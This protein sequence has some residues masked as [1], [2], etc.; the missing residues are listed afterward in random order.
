MPAI[1][2]YGGDIKPLDHLPPNHNTFTGCMGIAAHLLA[3]DCFRSG[4]SMQVQI[5][6]R[7]NNPHL[8]NILV[9]QDW[10]P[11]EDEWTGINIKDVEFEDTQAW[12]ATPNCNDT[13]NTWGLV[14]K[15]APESSLP[16]I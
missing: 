15:P 4:V 10:N 12:S 11:T 9:A 5:T 14:C 1:T 13:I 8:F 2:L 3:Q 7:Q 16:D 6:Q